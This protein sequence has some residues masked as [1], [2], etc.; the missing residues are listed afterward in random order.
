[1]VVHNNN[2]YRELMAYA[3]LVMRKNNEDHIINN[4]IICL[5]KKTL[6]RYNVRC[7]IRR[8]F[9]YYYYMYTTPLWKNKCITSDLRIFFFYL[10]QTIYTIFLIGEEKGTYMYFSQRGVQY[11][12]MCVSTV[13]D[14]G[15]YVRVCDLSIP[16]NDLTSGFIKIIILN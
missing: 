8:Y 16:Y 4:N 12:N 1:M 14:E 5:K 10:V 2:Y 13:L 6:I 15:D 9:I 3:Y 7:R 11:H